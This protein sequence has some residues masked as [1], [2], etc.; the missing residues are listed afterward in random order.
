DLCQRLDYPGGRAQAYYLAARWVDAEEHDVAAI[1]REGNLGVVEPL[2]PESR[3]LLE[4]LVVEGR[5][6]L[7]EE[8]EEQYL[9]AP[10]ATREGDR[11]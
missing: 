10:E 1:A 6:R 8:L 11:G 9:E 4:E 5:S 2:G 3:A 7:L